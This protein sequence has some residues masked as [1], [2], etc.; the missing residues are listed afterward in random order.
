M[1]DEIG[2]TNKEDLLCYDTDA[3]QLFGKAKK[4]FF[5]T[6]I[7]QVKK[8]V[9]TCKSDIVP[10]G[11]G[12]TIFGGSVPNNS[13]VIDLTK[14]NKIYDLKIDQKTICVGAG[15]TLKELNEKLEKISFEFPIQPINHEDAT[16]GGLIAS[17]MLITRRMRYQTIKDWIETINFING[18][19]ELMSTTKTNIMD[20]CGMEGI[21][22]IIVSVVLKIV[23]KIE[24]S[25]S[26]FQSDNLE[27][28]FELIQKLK[29]EPMINSIEFYP[30][31]ISK[32]LNLP[33]KYN[34][35][36]EFDS[37]RGKI[38]AE[39]YE[40]LANLKNKL[41][42][43]LISEEYSL[44][45]T[46]IFFFDKLKEM[47]I[48]LEKTQIP[49]FGFLGSGIISCFFKEKEIIKKQ[50]FI[51]LIKKI[52]MKPEK[53]IIGLKRKYL[54]EDLEKELIKR[55]KL[56]Q[57]PNCKFNKN[58]LIDFEELSSL[59]N[60]KELKT[61]ENPEQK[62]QEFM[63]EVSKFDAKSKSFAEK[64]ADYKEQLKDY[65][66]TFKSQSSDERKQKIEDFARKIPNKIK[67]EKEKDFINQ[68][69]TNKFKK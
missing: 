10:R 13:V 58:K 66:D 14:M 4:V 57:D 31:K 11:L 39:E 59:N 18:K 9:K 34:L 23:P 3:S 28:L 46:F 65:E 35:I 68:I 49:Y 40:K 20:V 52:R 1:M 21:S 32:L 38:C 51:K 16:I 19:G 29:S 26:V 25:I 8:I 54:L 45:E 60:F 50:E 55:I 56:R 44:N 37:N 2:R 30:P 47:I 15:M 67:S 6:T 7:E 48:Y 22:G 41:Y 12:T 33:E 53:Y 69:M 62:M 36:I 61:K 17:N 63:G 64:S 43:K 42:C 24:R 27:G 5:P